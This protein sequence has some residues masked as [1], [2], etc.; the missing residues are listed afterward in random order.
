MKSMQTENQ[1]GAYLERIAIAVLGH[2]ADDSAAVAQ[3]AH[4][5]AAPS[6]Q[7][8]LLAGM[9]AVVLEEEFEVAFHGFV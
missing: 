2:L 1:N 4:L 7:T 3:L 6:V 5:S 9:A 8:A